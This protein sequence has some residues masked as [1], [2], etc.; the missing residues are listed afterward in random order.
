MY[1]RCVEC[2]H[3][4]VIEPS[5]LPPPYLY[6]QA[7]QDR[8]TCKALEHLLEGARAIIEVAID[9]FMV[10][11]FE[12]LSPQVPIAITNVIVGYT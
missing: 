11:N 10:W 6:A 5:L 8:A 2:L 9:H 3:V 12:V 1:C 7:E 4:W